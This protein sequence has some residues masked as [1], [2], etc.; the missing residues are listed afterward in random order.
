MSSKSM[1]LVNRTEQMRKVRRNFG[2]GD[3]GGGLHDRPALRRLA[4]ADATAR[5]DVDG[6]VNGVATCWPLRCLRGDPTQS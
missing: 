6:G 1:G 5:A 4:R 2:R 3:A